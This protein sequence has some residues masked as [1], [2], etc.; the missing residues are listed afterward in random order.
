MI[1]SFCDSCY[2]YVTGEKLDHCKGLNHKFTAEKVLDADSDKIFLQFVKDKIQK[3]VIDQ[4]D[5]SKLFVTVVI[6]EDIYENM[7]IESK[8]LTD[9]MIYSIYK[10]HEKILTKDAVERLLNLIRIEALYNESTAHEQIHLRCAST[11]ERICYDLANSKNSIVLIENEFPT[12]TTSKIT[13]DLPIF[14][15][16]KTMSEVPEPIYDETNRLDEFCEMLRMGDDLVFRVHLISLFLSHIAVPIMVVVGQE[17]SAKTT[18]TELIKMLIDPSGLNLESQV[19]GFP[20][21]VDDIT[22]TLANRYLIAYDNV[23]KISLDQSDSIC[24]AIT[25]GGQ[26]KRKLYTDNEESRTSYQRKIIFTGITI[27]PEYGDLT[28]RS[29]SY[30]TDR[31]PETERL[32]V[33]SILSWFKTIRPELLGEIFTILGKSLQILSEV[34]GETLAIPDMADYAIWGEAISRVMGNPNGKFIQDYAQKLASNS[35]ILNES[36]PA[37]QFFTEELGN[38]PEIEFPISVWHQKLDNFADLN[39]C[40]KNS[41]NYPRNSNKMRGWIERSKPIL[42]K[43]E[44]KVEFYQSTG[45]KFKKNNTI[46]KVKKEGTL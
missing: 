10:E 28:R 45:K 44:L 8:D 14:L 13:E 3:F 25:G 40:D 32:T 30:F 17:G 21:R 41:D 19:M 42:F 23:S 34:R 9:Y 29:I 4:S 38:D 20:K 39:G 7:D 16:T 33:E 2:E 36:N 12:L 18:K 26:S 27:S 1:R 46:L 11:D 35:E 24:M 15:H 6:H 22:N 5:N 43:A 37:V 31:I